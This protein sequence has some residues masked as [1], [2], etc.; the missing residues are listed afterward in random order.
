MSW[1]MILS[2]QKP[3]ICFVFYGICK[4]FTHLW[5]RLSRAG[6]MHDVWKIVMNKE[7]FKSWGKN[8]GEFFSLII[9]LFFF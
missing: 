1:Q 3:F 5:G 8:N 9:F 2:L 7:K 6:K 4:L